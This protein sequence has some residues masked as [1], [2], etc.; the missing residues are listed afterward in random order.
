MRVLLSDD[1]KT[2]RLILRN[3]LWELGLQD[4][5]EASN[6]REALAA[7]NE[8][9]YDL[10]LLDIHMPEVDGLGVLEALKSA[11]DSAYADVPVVIISSDTDYRQIEKARDL[12]AY[13][14]IKKPF[15]KEGLEAAINAARQA[16]TGASGGGAVADTPAGAADPCAETMPP[17]AAD[18]N[19]NGSV[20]SRMPRLRRSY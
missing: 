10:I 5:D 12:G 16:M 17:N 2:I 20:L 7:L 8:K 3:L 19:G 15:K 4:V 13:G 14:Y 9:Q 6:G 18:G 1:S 11:P